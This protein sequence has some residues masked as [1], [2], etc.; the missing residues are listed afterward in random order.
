ML[1]YSLLILTS[2]MTISFA[3]MKLVLPKIKTVRDVSYSAIAAYAAD[4]ALELC[5]YKVRKGSNP[6]P[7]VSSGVNLELQ[8]SFPEG[9]GTLSADS[10]ANGSTASF[11]NGTGWSAAGRFQFAPIFD[12]IDDRIDVA[13]PVIPTGD[14]TW[15]VWVW[16]N[17]VTG[18][19]SIMSIGSSAGTNSLEM[20]LNGNIFEMRLNGSVLAATQAISAGTWTHLAAVRQG[21]GVSLYVNAVSAGSG[22]SSAVFNF[23]TCQLLLGADAG[24]GCSTGLLSFLNGKIDEAR[25]YSQALT[26]AEV[27]ASI[28]VPPSLTMTNGS[29]FVLYYPATTSNISTCSEAE[30][31]HR[32]VGTYRGIGRS[33]EVF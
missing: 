1:I 22:F 9:T 23:G 32:A 16:P 12:G 11:V 27:T 20:V 10:S 7:V 18:V 28:P 13:N 19:Q 5:V 8:L 33:F 21:S 26:Q 29:T 15:E 30:F 14:F 6:P 2:I 25:I 24:S 31:N 17:T 3:L 4:S